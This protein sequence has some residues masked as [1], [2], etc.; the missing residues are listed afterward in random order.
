MP[1]KYRVCIIAPPGY[2]HSSCFLEVAWLLAA[3]ISELG[4]ECDAKLNE[5]D[6]ERVNILLGGHLLTSTGSLKGI[7]YIPYQLEQLSSNEGAWNDNLN[8]LLSQ[9]TEV[10]DYSVENIAFLAT[11]GIS[12]KHVPV[13]YHRVLERIPDI[14]PKE[15]DVLFYGSLGGRR[16]PLLD[17]LAASG[18]LKVKAIFGVYGQE[19]DAWISRSKIV[20]NIH[21]YDVKIFEAVR[22]SYLINNRIFVLSEESAINP[23]PGVTIPMAPYD[24]IEDAIRMYLA[25][26]HL[27]DKIRQENYESFKEKYPMIKMLEN[28]LRIN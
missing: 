22:I 11:K 14:Q 6:K 10:W 23:Y 4:F 8:L 20:L 17:K 21:Y 19:R 3:S 2:I 18:S 26:D 7:R 27:R 25:D 28:V 12:A 1:A 15:A 16:K 13:G 24:G 5:P 9:A